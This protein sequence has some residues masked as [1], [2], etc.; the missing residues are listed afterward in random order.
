MPYRSSCCAV[1]SGKV[2]LFCH[3]LFQSRILAG[4]YAWNSLYSCVNCY[5]A[6]CTVPK[7]CISSFKLLGHW[8]NSSL[9]PQKM[10]FHSNKVKGNLK[11]MWKKN[12]SEA[13]AELVLRF[14]SPSRSSAVYTRQAFLLTS[15]FNHWRGFVRTCKKCSVLHFHQPPICGC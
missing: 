12:I 3:K 10:W 8:V 7:T 14:C 15:Y 5:I 6:T 2:Q 9:E 13:P 4:C 11:S 1:W